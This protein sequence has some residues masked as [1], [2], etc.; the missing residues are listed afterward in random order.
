MLLTDARRPRAPG[1]RRADSARRA[2]SSAVGSRGDRRRRRARHRDAV[3]RI[4]RRRISCRPRSPRCT[5][6]RR[7]PRT[8]TGRRSSRST[9]C[10]SGCPTT[11]WSRSTTRSPRRW[12]TGPQPGSK[13]LERSTRDERI[14]GHYRLDAV[15]AHLLERAGDR[16]AAIEHYQSR[17]AEN[18]EHPRA[19]LPDWQGRA[20]RRYAGARPVAGRVSTHRRA[21][22]LMIASSSRPYAPYSSGML[23]DWPKDSTPS[24]TTR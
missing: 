24:G 10:S 5:T 17:G 9:A 14:A 11:R 18:H 23:P 19:Q 6:K 1:R 16:E 22:A 13:L 15:R 20:P 2:G 12:C 4:G 7:A 21:T 3:A 8:P